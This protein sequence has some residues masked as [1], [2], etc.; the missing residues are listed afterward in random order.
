MWVMTSIS[1]SLGSGPNLSSDEVRS[2]DLDDEKCEHP[3]GTE[4]MGVMT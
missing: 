1:A 3:M 2:G 4:L